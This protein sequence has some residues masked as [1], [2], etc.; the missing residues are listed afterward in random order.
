MEVPVSYFE[1]LFY[2][3]L[4]GS[5]ENNGNFYSVYPVPGQFTKPGSRKH[6]IGM[7]VT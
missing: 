2:H 5:V 4:V 1:V 3:L 7:L 6:E